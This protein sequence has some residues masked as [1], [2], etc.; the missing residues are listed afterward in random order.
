MSIAKFVS[1]S[2][3]EMMEMKCCEGE[4]KSYHIA[5]FTCLKGQ[6]KYEKCSLRC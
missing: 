2:V 5:M 3:Y 1:S 6:K 4:K